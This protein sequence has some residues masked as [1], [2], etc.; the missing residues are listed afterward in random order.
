M[1][2]HYPELFAE[3]AE[4]LKRAQAIA[5]RTHELSSF[6]VRVLKVED[7]GA[8]WTGRLTWHDACHALRDLNIKS[9][10]RSLI[11][12]YAVPSLLS[13]ITLIRVVVLAVLSQL[14]I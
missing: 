9:E 13:W 6:L 2:H 14:S 3:D 11:K 8:S 10:P 12:M 7:V 1:V 5:E 4:W